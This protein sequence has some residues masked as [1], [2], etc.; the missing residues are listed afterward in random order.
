MKRIILPLVLATSLAAPLHAQE[1]D[2]DT[3]LSLMEEGAKLFFRGIM[4]EME[5][6]MEDLRGLAD[7]M[8]PALRS[9]VDDMG[10]ALAELLNKIGDLSV[11]HPPEVLPNGDIILRR[12][13]PLEQ[14]E[15]PE[16]DIEL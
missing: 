11:Y 6:A 9:F 10:P 13:T 16:G 14:N 8:E 1:G 7:D 2:V 15:E 5:P 4:E 3:G 12:K